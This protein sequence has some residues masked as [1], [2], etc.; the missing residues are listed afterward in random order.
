MLYSC[1]PDS[2]DSGKK[3][4]IKTIPYFKDGQAHTYFFSTNVTANS[5]VQLRGW[6][7]LFDNNP[8]LREMH[9]SIDRVSVTF[10]SFAL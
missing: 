5:P 8:E 2:I 9:M 3:Q 7:F 6:L 10:T 4:V 1:H